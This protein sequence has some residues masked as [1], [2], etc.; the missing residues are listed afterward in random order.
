M[1][2]EDV[3]GAGVRGP[4]RIQDFIF[5]REL[6]EVY[7]LLDHVSGR[8]DKSLAAITGESVEDEADWIARI[9]EIG[10][11][12]TGTVI[13]RAA[14]AAILLRAKDRLN[15]AAKPATGATIAF[16]LLVAG[17]DNAAKQRDDS[18]G[19]D[20]PPASGSGWGGGD[21]PS[22]TSLARLAYP[23]L[24][25][26]AYWF[27][28]QTRLIIL[29]LLFWL[30]FTCALS[31]NIAAG[32]AILV[33]LDAMTAERTAILKKIADA[34]SEE[35]RQASAP[36]RS[37]I[38][39]AAVVA[40]P[41]KYFLRY[42]DRPRLLPARRTAAGEPIAQFTDATQRQICDSLAENRHNY[43]IGRDDLADWLAIWGWLKGVSHWIC[44]GPCLHDTRLE[45]AL[46]ESAVNEQWAAILAEVLA[47]AV[48][49][50][51]YGFLGAGAAVVRGLWGK[52]R[53]SLLSPRDLTLALGQLALGAVI[54]ACIGLFVTPSGA[55]PEGSV[56]LTGSVTLSASALSFIAGFGVEGVFVALEGLI[57]RVFN[58]ADPARTAP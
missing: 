3:E 17:E 36:P 51:C 10:W 37:E 22:R 41:P 29:L 23:G 35:A 6:S 5:A 11:P 7:L 47:S 32:R 53:D 2:S 27:R 58:I 55:P 21:P 1:T 45:A 4:E 50:L 15:A 56:G 12:P 42:C 48:L 38:A 33:R 28:L 16:T 19:D 25:S 31:W 49:P 13:Q 18:R 46:P 20:G 8:S 24:V 52:M 57:K 9:C 44:G 34:E 43:A 26:T 54:G 39:S 30:I 40:D 14:Q